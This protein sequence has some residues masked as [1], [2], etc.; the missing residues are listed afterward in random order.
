MYKIIG[1]DG[2]EYGP[3]TA[4]QIRAWIT[5]GRANSQSKAQLEGTTD[6]KPLS[7]FP[8]FADAFHPK[9]AEAT[10]STSNFGADAET[11]ASRILAQGY[12]VDAGSCL[13]RAWDKLMADL[14]PIIGVTALIWIALSASH[15][16]YV[17]ILLT[18]PLLGG[19]N[20]YYL[21]KIRNQPAELADA[22]AGF[23]I[24]FVQLLLA[25]LVSGLLMGVGYALCIVPG[26][27]LTVAWI[28]AL[29][30]VIDK[31]LRFWDAMEL[32]R[33]VVNLRWW[34]VAW[35]VLLC[36]LINIGG[37][38]VCCVGVFF[39]LPLTGLAMMYAYEDVFGTNSPA[40]S[41]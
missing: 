8:E 2:Q 9:P 27:Y 25:S 36:L 30:L 5:A 6:W 17:G 35:L 23:S 38:L 40:Q 4:D 14:W 39:T 1:I 31:Q 24:A 20:F 10:P 3:V 32:S 19:L 13:T 33:K 18:G 16:V 11:L 7:D 15:G 22:F 12:V 28:F 26:I 34:S 29:S 21:K 41:P 37:G